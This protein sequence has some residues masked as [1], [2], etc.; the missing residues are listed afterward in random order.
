MSSIEVWVPVGN[1]C[2]SLRVSEDETPYDNRRYV[3]VTNKRTKTLSV[4]SL[5]LNE[6][7]QSG[8]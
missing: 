5:C 8:R 3:S 2:V 4:F 6:G 1:S 7:V